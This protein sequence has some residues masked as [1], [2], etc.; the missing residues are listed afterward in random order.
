MESI[1][2]P[3]GSLVDFY[4]VNEKK[5]R[6]ESSV[7]FVALSFRGNPIFAVGYY[8]TFK[9]AQGR[10]VSETDGSHLEST[11]LCWA[12]KYIEK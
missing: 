2:L 7:L 6:S 1:K 12:D 3:N 4:T 11:V 8:K 5:P 9:T 10:F